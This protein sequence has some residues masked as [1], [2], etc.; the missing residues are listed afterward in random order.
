MDA[1][2]VEAVAGWAGM[3]TS[4]LEDALRTEWIE[5]RWQGHIGQTLQVAIWE[6]RRSNGREGWE[7]ERTLS[8]KSDGRDVLLLGR[9]LDNERVV[10]D[11]LKDPH[12]RRRG[13]T[14]IAALRDPDAFD[15]L[16][17]DG[18]THLELG[19]ARARRARNAV[20]HGNPVVLSVVARSRPLARHL[21]SGAIDLALRSLLEEKNLSEF[22]EQRA[23]KRRQDVTE[24]QAGTPWSTIWDRPESDE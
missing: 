7:L 13:E 12:D 19:L 23:T 3:E 11:S 14:V 6:S 16:Y 8:G 1:Q 20:T 22:L 21:S 5:G 2:I 4:D 9:A 24:F 15:Q 17:A 18:M 10:L